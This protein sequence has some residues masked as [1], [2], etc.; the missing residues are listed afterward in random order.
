MILKNS[1]KTI[2]D[3]SFIRAKMLKFLTLFKKFYLQKPHKAPTTKPPTPQKN[4]EKRS[5]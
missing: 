4:E 5:Q 1:R 2:F 3:S